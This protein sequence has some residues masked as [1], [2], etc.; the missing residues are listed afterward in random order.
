M[1][2]KRITAQTDVVIDSGL[3]ELLEQ[4]L[5]EASESGWA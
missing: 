2:Y 3:F 4:K 1:I 5:V